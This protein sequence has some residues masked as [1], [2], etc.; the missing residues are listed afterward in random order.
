L[1]AFAATALYIF[2]DW[3]TKSSISAGLQLRQEDFI[4]FLLRG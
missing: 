1:E 4:V 2:I 3:A